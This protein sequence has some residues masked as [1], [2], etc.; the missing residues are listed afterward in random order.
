MQT[1]HLKLIKFPVLSTISVQIDFLSLQLRI[2]HLVISVPIQFNHFVLRGMLKDVSYSTLVFPFSPKNYSIFF[3][4]YFVSLS[5]RKWFNFRLES[6][7]FIDSQVSKKMEY[8][9]LSLNCHCRTDI[10][11]IGSNK[12]LWTSWTDRITGYLCRLWDY[13]TS[14]PLIKISQHFFPKK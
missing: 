12:P 8:F 11:I 5:Q 14:S 13:W 7:L 6:A 9:W 3:E 2:R 1:S 4:L 10:G